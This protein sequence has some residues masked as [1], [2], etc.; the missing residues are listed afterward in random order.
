[1]KK[2]LL[3]TILLSLFSKYSFSQEKIEP[4]L[5]II[6]FLGNVPY[7]TEKNSLS[8][9][10]MVKLYFRPQPKNAPKVGFMN[11]KGKVL[12][13][14]IYDI[15]SDF[16]DG[17]ANIIKDSIYG[18][19]DKSGSE[20]LFRQYE[21]TYFYYGNTGI[22]KKNGKF[23]L[24]DRSGK[25]FTEFSY[26]MI[27]FFGFNNFRGLL[28]VDEHHIL[29]NKGTI[30]NRGLDFKIVSSYFS[31]DS[32]LIYENKINNNGLKGLAKM[33]NIKLT[34]AIYDQIYMIDDKDLLVVVKDRKYGFINMLGKEVI[35]LVYDE[36]GF[37]INDNLIPVKQKSKWGFVNRQNEIVI[38]LTFE[39]AY[40]FF[41]GISIVKK[42]N[43]FGG[44]DKKN[45]VKIQFENEKSDFPFFSNGL[46]VFSKNG[47][48]GYI[49][50]NGNIVIPAKYEYAYPFINS[51]AYVEEAGKAGFID[52]KGKSVIPINYRQLWMP[53]EGFIR[54]V[55]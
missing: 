28:S 35:P 33:G 43:L 4:N 49:D 52:K 23:G 32:L 40:A 31:A 15:A 55:D 41:D 19:I 26:R 12:L 54:F 22:A 10:L 36:V 9:S 8:Q 5:K 37:N 27:D 14:P 16:Y 44:I 17:Y 39:A 51:I 50:K 53:S 38:P 11:T 13:K 6:N 46:C 24:I 25:P 48:H 42:E 20:I 34:E 3:F 45:K 7:K 2:L 18:Y 21:E 30:I 29:D 47:K 1:M